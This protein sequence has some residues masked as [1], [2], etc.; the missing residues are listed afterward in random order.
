MFEAIT[1]ILQCPITKESLI[2]SQSFQEANTKIQNTPD[3]Q[4]SHGFFNESKTIFYPIMDGIICMM[5]EYS[6]SDTKETSDEDILSVKAFYDSFGWKKSDDGKYHDNKLF[7]DQRAV[8]SEYREVCSKRLGRFLEKGGEYLLD[9]ASGPVYQENNKAYSQHFKWR[10][11]IDISIQALKEAQQNL[12][13]YNVIFIVGDITN[14]PLKKGSCTKVISQHTLYHVPKAKQAEAIHELIRVAQP[15]KDRVIISYNWGWHSLLM[16]IALFPSRLVRLLKRLK[17]IFIPQS[18]KA[19]TASKLYFYSHSPGYFKKIKPV[20]SKVSFT[21]L[22]TL[23][24]NF[25]KLYLS[26]G[27]GSQRFLNWL[28]TLEN[29]YPAFFGKHGAF[30]LIVFQKTA[31]EKPAFHPPK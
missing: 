20:N 4:L 14:I 31:A 16:N 10:I 13:D 18:T 5:P 9:I 28:L 27:K 11:C 30:G 6:V 3:I 21:V 12:K 7:I 17:K 29:K 23:H 24:E 8:A 19:K 15:G 2:Y 22:R 1:D 26:T 25:I